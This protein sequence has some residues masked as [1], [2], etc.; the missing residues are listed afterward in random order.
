MPASASRRGPRLGRPPKTSLDA[1]LDAVEALGLETFTIAELAARLGVRDATLYNYVG[2]REEAYRA[3]CA[4]ILAR[5]EVAAAHASSWAEY[6]ETICRRG[7][8]LARAHPGIGPYIESGPYLSDSVRVFEAI[9]DEVR[10]RLPDATEDT[11]YA[12]AAPPF[13]VSVSMANDDD[14]VPLAEWIRQSMIEGMSARMQRGASVPQIGWRRFL[15][16]A[17]ESARAEPR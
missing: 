15:V 5:L 13:L 2:G 17:P 9:I 16:I 8:A 14:D 4:R 10:A 7:F 11:A 1:I 6:V 3:A 12:L